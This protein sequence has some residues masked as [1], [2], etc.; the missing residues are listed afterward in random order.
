MG[1]RLRRM[2]AGALASAGALILM[3]CANTDAP[4]T[5]AATVTVTGEADQAS[6]D[7][8]VCTIGATR[9]APNDKI[10]IYGERASAIAK[11]T[12]EVEAID[13][14]PDG[15]GV[16]RYK[17]HFDAIPA[18]QRS[19]EML[20]SDSFVEQ[21]FTAGELENGVTYVVENSAP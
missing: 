13:Q 19:Y 6:A 9:L 21:S 8:G 1:H 2:A 14:H 20:V 7:S 16:C 10:G 18:N 4:T 3:S 15:T 12:L 5:F 11:S 17:A